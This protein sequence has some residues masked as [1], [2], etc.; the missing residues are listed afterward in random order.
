MKKNDSLAILNSHLNTT[1]SLK[2]PEHHEPPRTTTMDILI[3]E[4][5]QVS[6]FVKRRQLT[7][8]SAVYQRIYIKMLRK[9]NCNPILVFN[10]QQ[11]LDYLANSANPRPRIIILKVCLSVQTY[12]I[13]RAELTGKDLP[14]CS[15]WVGNRTYPTD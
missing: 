10:G 6:P 14:A 11:A 5:K 12:A 7:A 13:Y 4:D 9:R 15:M 3:A 2:K 8:R 1:Q